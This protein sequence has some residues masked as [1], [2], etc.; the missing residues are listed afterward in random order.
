MK[1][2]AIETATE[3]CSA[4]LWL[5]GDI[6]E[7][8]ELAPR[9]HTELILPMVDVL[10]A[11]AGLRLTDMD[12]LVFGRGPGQFTGVRIA[13]GVIQGLALAA[14]R[15]VIGIS[16]LA[17]LAQTLIV[18]QQPVL[19]ALDARMDEVYWGC[20]WPTDGYMQLVDEECVCAPAD[21]PVAA[22]HNWLAAGSGW[23]RYARQLQ[24]RLAP[25]TINVITNVLPHASASAAL[26]SVELTAGR[27][28][29]ADRARPVYLRDRVVHVK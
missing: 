28:V 27:V 9:Q 7:R 17:S 11:E 19:A 2:L 16:T 13:T 3:A 25:L 24:T 22:G 8:F 5:D 12:A 21:A 20:Y 4:A 1:L 6:R 29:S 26:A 10:L 18:H 23:D 15:P 14:D